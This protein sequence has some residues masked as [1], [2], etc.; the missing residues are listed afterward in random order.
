LTG[1]IIIQDLATAALFDTGI[2]G[3][4]VE[5]SPVDDILATRLTSSNTI[6]L[7]RPDGTT[8][9]DVPGTSFT[10]RAPFHW[11]PDGRYILGDNF[12]LQLDNGVLLP[13]ASGAFNLGLRN[14]AWRPF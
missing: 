6:R 8:V 7:F 9:R 2:T 14:A 12:I 13:L 4:N 11:S 10:L 5:W 3:D 1:T